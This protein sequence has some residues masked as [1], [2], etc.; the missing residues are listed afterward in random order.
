MC[1]LK[2]PLKINCRY[3][4]TN[5]KILISN[6]KSLVI[7]NNTGSYYIPIFMTMQ[8]FAKTAKFLY[9]HEFLWII[10]SGISS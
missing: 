3:D 4:T 10:T 9:C 5:K 6:G 8:K 2:Y 7:K 1:I